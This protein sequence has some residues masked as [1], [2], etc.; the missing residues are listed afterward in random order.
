MNTNDPLLS[1]NDYSVEQKIKYINES[2]KQENE[3]LLDNSK[4][5]YCES[6]CESCCDCDRL[7][8]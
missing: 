7:K 8:S 6:C 4:K 1:T 5:S 2:K 3:E